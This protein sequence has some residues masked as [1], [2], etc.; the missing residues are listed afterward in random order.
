MTTFPQGN[1]VWVRAKEQVVLCTGVFRLGV[2]IIVVISGFQG[3]VLL[4]QGFLFLPSIAIFNPF[5]VFEVNLIH[6]QKK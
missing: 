6:V 3:K 4:H 5:K 2:I 1:H